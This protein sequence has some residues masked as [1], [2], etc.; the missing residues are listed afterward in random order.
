MKTLSTLLGMLLLAAAFLTAC[1]SNGNGTDQALVGTWNRLRTATEL[2]DR[3]QFGANGS[4]AFD[5]N[6][7]G[8]P[9][10]E[11][12][13][14]GTYVASGGVVTAT[15]TNTLEPGQA[16]LTFSY[17]AGA[18][19]FSSGAL[20][21]RAG[22]TGIVGVWTGV[23][24]IERLDGSEQSPAGDEV[25][26]EFR[27]DG[28]Y[29]WTVTPFDG[30]AARVTEGTWVLEGGT[31]FRITFGSSD[32]L[33]QLFDDQVLGTQVLENQVLQNQVLIDASRI[34]QRQ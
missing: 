5:E 4:F 22:H 14:T 32:L 27:A 20:R 28:S 24:K 18:T 33:F 34:W 29:R 8:S 6:K 13:M 23:V 3:Y 11:D 30:T 16:R 17:Y 31:M 1:D 19:Q 26:A 21:A 10:T 15:V 9:Q 25:E 12:H 7:P 2:R